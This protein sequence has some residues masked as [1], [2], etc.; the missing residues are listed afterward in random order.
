[1]R[2][3]PNSS[4]AETRPNVVSQDSYSSEQILLTILVFLQEDRATSTNTSII[5]IEKKK[6]N[7]TTLT[8]IIFVMNSE[9]DRRNHEL[10]SS[11]S[12]TEFVKV[13]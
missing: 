5:K 12:N 9:E 3:Q 10:G 11:R 7:R 13:E 8:K 1:M 6:S 2:I 4:L